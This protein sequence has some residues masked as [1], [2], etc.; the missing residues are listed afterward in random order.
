MRFG[1]CRRG[2][3]AISLGEGTDR[4]VLAILSV[5]Q[6]P[7]PDQEANILERPAVLHRLR[8]FGHFRSR[9]DAGL[10]VHVL[11]VE[12]QQHDAHRIG[13]VGRKFQSLKNGVTGLGFQLEDAVGLCL[14]AVE[15]GDALRIGRLGREFS[16]QQRRD[17]FEGSI[18]ILVD[19][20]LQGSDRRIRIG[21]AGSRGRLERNCPRQQQQGKNARYSRSGSTSARTPGITHDHREITGFPPRVRYLMSRFSISARAARKMHLK[22]P[23]S[24]I[25]VACAAAVLR[26]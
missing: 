24:V 12:R 1:E 17:F 20:R 3:G 25:Q 13:V 16:L 19:Q 23:P 15:R 5:L 18:G 26:T 11:R 14:H 9:A 8:L 21:Q 7:A 2:A 22:R 10:V 4:Q 6:Q